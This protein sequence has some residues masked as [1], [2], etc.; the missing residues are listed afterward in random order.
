MQKDL[1]VHVLIDLQPL[2][3]REGMFPRDYEK[4]FLEVFDIRTV[5]PSARCLM[6]CETVSPP[7]FTR[8]GFKNVDIRFNCDD[9][10]AP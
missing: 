3:V 1:Q 7:W 2:Q 9:A 10:L 6:A 4:G 5:S 8:Y